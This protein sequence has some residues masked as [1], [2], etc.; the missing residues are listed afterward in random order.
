MNNAEASP[1]L[2]ALDLLK[3]SPERMTFE[4]LTEL[5]E[6]ASKTL[7]SLH[8]YMCWIVGKSSSESEHANIRSNKLRLL[9][10]RIKDLMQA[11]QSVQAA[12]AFTAPEQA[13]NVPMMGMPSRRRK[14]VISTLPNSADNAAS[15]PLKTLG[16]EPTAQASEAS[17]GGEAK[18]APPHLNAQH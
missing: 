17:R 10:A 11:K 1:M 2:K 16:T 4:E 9:L 5:H 6:E 8:Q 14:R 12:M 13:E 15:V 3:I 7:A 18:E